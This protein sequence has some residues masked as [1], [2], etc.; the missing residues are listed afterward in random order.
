M[1]RAWLTAAMEF[2]D[3]MAIEVMGRR[4]VSQSL[5]PPAV[6][7]VPQKSPG[8]ASGD[9]E[10][11]MLINIGVYDYWKA[12]EATLAFRFFIDTIIGTAKPHRIANPFYLYLAMAATGLYCTE[13]SHIG[14][15]AAPWNW[16]MRFCFYARHWQQ[17]NGE[18]CFNLVRGPLTDCCVHLSSV[19]S[20]LN[21]LTQPLHPPF[22]CSATTDLPTPHFLQNLLSF[23]KLQPF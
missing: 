14:A 13:N 17:R 1:V 16:A 2:L 8:L 10:G 18:I 21:Q 11:G 5:W 9:A 19:N 4:A 20:R 22:H 15:V 12:M 3:V 7:Q 6:T 23:Q